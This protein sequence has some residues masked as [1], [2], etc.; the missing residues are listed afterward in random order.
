MKTPTRTPFDCIAFKRAVQTTIFEETRDL[1][2]DEQIEWFQRTAECGPLGDWFR[3]LVHPS[4]IE[5][6]TAT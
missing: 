5:V 6:A 2:P 4:T 3:A 1:S